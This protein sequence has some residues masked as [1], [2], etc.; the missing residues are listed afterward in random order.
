MGT[1]RPDR[2]LRPVQVELARI[3]AAE[4][5]VARVSRPVSRTFDSDSHEFTHSRQICVGCEDVDAVPQRDRR[6]HAIHHAS[7]RDARAAAQPVYAGGAIEVDGWIES[8]QCEPL[9]EPAQVVLTV[10][11]PGT[12]KNFHDH[13]FCHGNFIC[14]GDQGGWLL[15]DP[16]ACGS[17]ELDPR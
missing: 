7:W 11:G 12:G 3:P 1:C 6:D 14:R 17:I 8:K 5:S 13:G 2:Q 16:A 9:H 10:I 4:Q 15:V